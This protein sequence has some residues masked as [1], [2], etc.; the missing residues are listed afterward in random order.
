M[1]AEALRSFRWKEC[2]MI[3]QGAQNAFNPVLR[4]RDQV[5]DTARAH[6]ESNTDRVRDRMLD[7]VPPSVA[8]S[9][10]GNERLSA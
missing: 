10:S 1:D 8:R 4:I 3:F 9:R 6:G 5:W 7:L 2:A